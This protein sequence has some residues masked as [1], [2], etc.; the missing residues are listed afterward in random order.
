[1]FRMSNRITS[2]Y[3]FWT[4]AFRTGIKSPRSREMI[5]QDLKISAH[6]CK[7]I[8]DDT[9]WLNVSC[10]T[11]CTMSVLTSSGGASATGPRAVERVADSGSGLGASCASSVELRRLQCPRLTRL[12]L[13]RLPPRPIFRPGLRRPPVC[14]TRHRPSSWSSCHGAVASGQSTDWSVVKSGVRHDG[15][16]T[17]G[18]RSVAGSGI[19][20]G[21]NVLPQPDGG[22]LWRRDMDE[23]ENFTRTNHRVQL[24]LS[25]VKRTVVSLRNNVYAMW[26]PNK[27]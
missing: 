17:S 3:K 15:L 23:V 10:Q 25:L 11:M 19:S 2:F 13:P 26:S 6:F 22:V 24:I 12:P 14:V 1:M 21:A 20:G 18:P 4:A 5:E 16:P 8:D 9:V 7:R 27:L